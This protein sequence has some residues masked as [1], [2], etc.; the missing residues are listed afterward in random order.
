MHTNVKS[1]KRTKINGILL[2]TNIRKSILNKKKII[3][4]KG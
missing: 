1:M 2:D 3:N 4:I